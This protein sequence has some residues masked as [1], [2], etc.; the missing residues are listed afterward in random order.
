MK[1]FIEFLNLAKENQ[2]TIPMLMNRYSKYIQSIDAWIL[3]GFN[4][5]DKS[6]VEVYKDKD[7]FWIE[8][9]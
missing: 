4:A 7:G 5:N 9:K 1:Q 2:K 8:P 6:L 3:N